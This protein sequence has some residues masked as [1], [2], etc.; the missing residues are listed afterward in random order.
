MYL[1]MIFLL[2]RHFWWLIILLYTP[3]AV[4]M[5]RIFKRA[6]RPWWWGIIPILNVFL[7]WPLAGQQHLLKYMVISWLLTIVFGYLEIGF[8]ALLASLSTWVLLF[9]MN[10]SLA[11]NFWWKKSAACLFALSTWIWYYI[12]WYFNDKYIW[13]TWELHFDQNLVDNGSVR[14]DGSMWISQNNLWVANNLVNPGIGGMNWLWANW[15]N[16]NWSIVGWNNVVSSSNV[17][18]NALSWNSAI[19]NNINW[20]NIAWNNIGTSN[21][22]LSGRIQEPMNNSY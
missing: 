12:L 5:Y 18:R 14:S 15:N 1:Q 6:D 4:A 21:L 13:Y 9:I 16:V 3:F 7:L 17:S 11:Q 20:I 10:Y 8:L 22:N 19:V 2:I